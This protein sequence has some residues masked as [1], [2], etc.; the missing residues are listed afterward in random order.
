MKDVLKKAVSFGVVTGFVVWGTCVQASIAEKKLYQEAFPD[1][2]VK[3]VD[4]HTAA[5]PKKEDG[6]HE[7]NAYGKAVLEAAKAD[8]TAEAKPTVDTYK[9]V[10]TIEDFQK[11]AEVAPEA[12][13]VTE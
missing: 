7:N 13:P 9:K 6:E 1:A 10:G 2:T 3:C 4:C 5:M 12:A 11:K 8:A